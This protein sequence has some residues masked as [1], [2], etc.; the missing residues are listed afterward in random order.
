M[1]SLLI[2]S[3]LILA[4]C[5]Q[6]ID[7]LSNEECFKENM[8]TCNKA[9]YSQC[10]VFGNCY[11]AEIIGEEGNLCTIRNWESKEDKVTNY[12]ATCTS[13]KNIR[14]TSGSFDRPDKENGKYISPAYICEHK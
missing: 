10:S 5:T 12:D 1:V 2:I 14:F 13:Q 9:V 7:C 11:N 3:A 4:G 8:L 6:K